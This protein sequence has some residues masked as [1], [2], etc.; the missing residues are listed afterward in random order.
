MSH[1]LGALSTGSPGFYGRLGWE[2][3]RGPTYVRRGD[4]LVRTPDE[5]AGIM[6]LRFGPSAG[7]DLA[8]PISSEARAGDDW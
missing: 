1:D 2:R 7:V 5:D 4:D 8:A 6:V 3:W